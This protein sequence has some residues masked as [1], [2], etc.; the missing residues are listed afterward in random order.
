MKLVAYAFLA[1]DGVLQGPGGAEE[2]RGLTV[3]DGRE[4][5]R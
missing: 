3:Q 5:V 1:L 2:D 4:A